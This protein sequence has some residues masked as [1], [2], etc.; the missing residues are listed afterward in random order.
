MKHKALKR[1]FSAF[2]ALLMCL[3]TLT[4]LTTTV[5]AA[6]TVDAYMVD[7]PRDGDSNYSGTTWGHPATELM[8]GWS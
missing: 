7:F 3:T 8:S 6:A 2:L 4:S 1:G 5:F